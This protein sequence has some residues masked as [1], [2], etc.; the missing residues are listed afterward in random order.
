VK[1][2]GEFVRDHRRHRL[3]EEGEPFGDPSHRDQH[4]S[5]RKERQSDHVAMVEPAADLVSL[6]G[7]CHRGVEIAAVL[8]E[9]RLTER[10]ETVLYARLVIVQVPLRPHQPP[11]R[12]RR[13]AAFDMVEEQQHRVERSLGIITDGGVARVR[14]LACG[15]RFV[16]SRQPP[17]RI[18]QSFEVPRAQPSGIRAVQR[19]EGL[20]PGVPREGIPGSVD[21]GRS[22]GHVRV[23]SGSRRGR[24]WRR[25]S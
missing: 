9:G 23:S 7:E 3:V 20:G 19:V 13:V 22:L 18:R 25:V 15:D 10:Q 14:A 5:P 12:D 21:V 6:L 16:P 4:L 8:G 11:H 1:Y 17:G 2:G 24:R